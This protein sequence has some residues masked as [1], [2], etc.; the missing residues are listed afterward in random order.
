MVRLT[1]GSLQCEFDEACQ[2]IKF[3]DT[4]WHKQKF[5]H[6]KAMDIL[7]TSQGQHWWIEIKDC[8]GHEL[9]N[10]SRLSPAEPEELAAARQWAAGQ[11]FERIVRIN[12][13]KPFIIDEVIE[14]MRDTLVALNF[15]QRAQDPA[16][17]AHAP[18]CG[19]ALPLTVVLLLTWDV[20]DFKR[21]ARLLQQKLT[22]AL[23]PYGLNGFVVNET[24]VRRIGIP[25][26]VSRI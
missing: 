20:R 2:A 12:R 4:A 9:A 15:A 24:A 22:S 13:C 6:Y 5:G 14:K 26:S 16:L 10:Q 3:D 7:A 18:W 19:S 23:L 17:L 25:C 11:G 1:E 8:Q 21:F